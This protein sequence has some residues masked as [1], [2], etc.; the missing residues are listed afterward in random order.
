MDQNNNFSKEDVIFTYTR[1]QAIE[2]GVLIDVS[3]M[4]ME[5]GFRYPVAVVTNRIT[6]PLII[7]MLTPC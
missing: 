1:K 2:D 3:E 5:A 6:D 7:G 4:A